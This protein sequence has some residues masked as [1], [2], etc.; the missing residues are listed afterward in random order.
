[1]KSQARK[2]FPRKIVEGMVKK[3]I[4]GEIVFVVDSGILYDSASRADKYMQSIES[5]EAILE[6]QCKE[7]S[8]KVEVKCKALGADFVEYIK[9]GD[10]SRGDVKIDWPLVDIIPILNYCKEKGVVTISRD[11]VGRTCFSAGSIAMLIARKV[12]KA[13]KVDKSTKPR[14]ETKSDEK[15][16]RS[17]Q[18]EIHG[19]KS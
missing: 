14:K 7:G 9:L 6:I 1:V 13:L 12:A 5:S 11:K 3:G 4:E 17:H 16:R 8:S 19:E 10:P 18:N 2:N 15:S